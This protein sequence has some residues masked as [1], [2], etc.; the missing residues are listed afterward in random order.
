MRTKHTVPARSSGSI[1]LPAQCSRC[2]LKSW[3]RGY[4]IIIIILHHNATPPF[5][6]HPTPKNRTTMMEEGLVK[7]DLRRRLKCAPS[8]TVSGDVISSSGGPLFLVKFADPLSPLLNYFEYVIENIGKESAIGIGVGERDY[9]MSAMPGWNPNSCG[10]HA[11]DGKLFLEAGRGTE[12][13]STC[14][15]GDSMGCGVDF[16]CEQAEAGSVSVFFTKNGQQVGRV[17]KLKRPDQ[18]LYPMIGLHSGGEQV[19]YLGHSRRDMGTL[20]QLMELGETQVWLR[21]NGTRF[22][23]DGLTLE[24]AGNEGAGQADVG[25]AQSRYCLSAAQHYFEIEILNKGEEG[26]IFIGAGM[27]THPLHLYPGQDERSVGYLASDGCLYKGSKEE[28]VAFGPICTVGDRMGCGLKF[29]GDNESEATGNEIG[30][31]GDSE[32]DGEDNEQEELKPDPFRFGD[33]L[34]RRARLV[35]QLRKH[36]VLRKPL[37]GVP[38][39]RPHPPD[40]KASDVTSDRTCVVF[41]TKNDEVV[42]ETKVNLPRGGLYPLVAMT[43]RG[44]QVRVNFHPLTG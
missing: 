32:S 37:K 13:A 5:R 18:G 9:S 3:A 17:V 35:Q 19:R 8:I 26:H 1:L 43:T 23:D 2:A 22:L 7:V 27:C 30:P 28:G 24:Y 39:R 38:H 14:T 31:S 25:I 10:Y 41:F 40:R 12:F 11:D 36:Y 4:V 42:G 44:E 29:A 6:P 20:A 16:D 21:S 33:E 15:T 34:L